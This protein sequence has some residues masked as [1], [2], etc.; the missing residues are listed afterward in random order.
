MPL[1]ARCGLRAQ[2]WL[3]GSG[4]VTFV[5]PAVFTVIF[6]LPIWL[7]FFHWFRYFF[8]TYSYSVFVL[9]VDRTWM[10]YHHGIVQSLHSIMPLWWRQSVCLSA[11]RRI[12]VNSVTQEQYIIEYILKL[13]PQLSFG[14][15]FLSTLL[16]ERYI[17]LS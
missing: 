4:R 14:C 12:L 3:E 15:G 2:L 13:T 10:S 17:S 9:F 7:S 8:V 1:S 16:C 6:P 11:C 5:I